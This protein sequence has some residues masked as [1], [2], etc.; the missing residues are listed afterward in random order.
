[1]SANHILS[2]RYLHPLSL[3]WFLSKFLFF[4]PKSRVLRAGHCPRLNCL[5]PSSLIKLLTKFPYNY[6]SLVIEGKAMSLHS[7]VGILYHQFHL[8]LTLIIKRYVNLV[9]REQAIAPDRCSSILKGLYNYL[10][11][12]FDLTY[13]KGSQNRPLTI[14]QIFTFLAIADL[15]L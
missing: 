9:F 6:I 8:N 2:T 4:L 15:A 5:H 7:N 13:I 10:L 14:I 12:I 1:M 3:I 11:N